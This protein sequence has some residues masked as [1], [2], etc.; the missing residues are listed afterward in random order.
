M[1]LKKSYTTP[2]LYR[3]DLKHEQAILSACSLMT[4]N[5]VSGFGTNTCRATGF[6]P[7]KAGDSG[8]GMGDS[9]P[10]LS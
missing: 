4:M 10:R 9:G 3:V 6:F 2:S 8:F 1:S 7:C 5:N